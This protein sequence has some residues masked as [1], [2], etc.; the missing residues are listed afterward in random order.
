MLCCQ[1]SFHSLCFCHDPIAPARHGL[2]VQKW[3]ACRLLPCLG[4]PVHT[5]GTQ[6]CHL[7]SW[8]LEPAI[9]ANKRCISNGLSYCWR[10]SLGLEILDGSSWHPKTKQSLALCEQ[11]CYAGRRLGLSRRDSLSLG[12]FCEYQPSR[13]VQSSLGTDHMTTRPCGGCKA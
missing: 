10:Q 6:S 4:V 13:H 1:G 12:S 9:R 11:V 5:W 7:S 2:P 8:R 3:G